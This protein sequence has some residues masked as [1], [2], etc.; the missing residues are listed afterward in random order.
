MNLLEVLDFDYVL[1]GPKGVPP[2]YMEFPVSP[3]TAPYLVSSTRSAIWVSKPSMTNTVRAAVRPRQGF[4]VQ[5][6]DEVIEAGEKYNWGNVHDLSPEGLDK[7]VEHLASYGLVEIDVLLGPGVAEGLED[8][9]KDPHED[10]TEKGLSVAWHEWP[11]LPSDVVVVVPRDRA[12]LGFVA[13]VGA[14]SLV[15]VIHNPSRGLAIAYSKVDDAAP[16]DDAQ[17]V[18]GS[19]QSVSTDE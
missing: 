11:E 9:L 13:S 6:L 8:W 10:K 12:Y 15:S 5:V 4:L 7:A 18:S 14:G 17:L 2:R 19:S 1:R 3:E 16:T